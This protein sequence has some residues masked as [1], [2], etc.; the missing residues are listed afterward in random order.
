M[1]TKTMIVLDNEA[2]DKVREIMRT[3]LKRQFGGFVPKQVSQMFENTL[4]LFPDVELTKEQRG[5]YLEPETVLLTSNARNSSCGNVWQLIES[6]KT[7]HHSG[8]L[9]QPATPLEMKVWDL[10]EDEYLRL[11][12]NRDLPLEQRQQIADAWEKR[13]DEEKELIETL[14]DKDLTIEERLKA[15]YKFED[16]VNPQDAKDVENGLKTK[17]TD[18]NVTV[19]DKIDDILNK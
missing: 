8:A 5:A 6:Y 4:R 18:E 3:E 1:S 7:E 10:S 13:P 2:A 11:A 17:L 9:A 15:V 14:L 16:E 12:T 19:L